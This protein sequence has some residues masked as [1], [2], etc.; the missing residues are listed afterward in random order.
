MT[1]SEEGDMTFKTPFPRFFL[2]QSFSF[3]GFNCTV[4]CEDNEFGLAPHPDL[5]HIRPGTERP[6]EERTEKHADPVEVQTSLGTEI[7]EEYNTEK[8]ADAVLTKPNQ[9]LAKGA[10]TSRA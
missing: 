5:S 10:R 6:I 7:P 3:R 8:Y 4:A 1:K 9:N 2:L